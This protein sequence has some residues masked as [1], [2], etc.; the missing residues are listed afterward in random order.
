M[1][2]EILNEMLITIEKA[3][4]NNNF[5][6]DKQKVCDLYTSLKNIQYKLPNLDEI[7]K[8]KKDVNYLEIKYDEFNDLS[9]YFT[10]LYIEIKNK[11]HTENVKK[12]REKNRKKRGIK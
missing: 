11:I 8:L 3:L 7:E 12:I 10:P 1:K 2:F 4:K 6:E 9:Y 5:N